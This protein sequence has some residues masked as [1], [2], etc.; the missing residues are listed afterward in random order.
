MKWFA[1]PNL[2]NAPQRGYRSKDAM[3]ERMRELLGE[4]G[5]FTA[6][7]NK[8]EYAFVITRYGYE[9]VAFNPYRVVEG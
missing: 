9:R 8:G 7:N 3:F 2:P 6:E 1:T 4:G 5:E